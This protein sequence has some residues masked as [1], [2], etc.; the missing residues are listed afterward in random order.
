[1]KKPNL[2]GRAVAFALCFAGIVSAATGCGDEGTGEDGNESINSDIGVAGDALRSCPQPRM[3]Q[4]HK[5]TQAAIQLL[6]RV[7]NE[8]PDNQGYRLALA[9]ATSAVGNIVRG[10][11]EVEERRAC[12]A[13][14]L[15]A[16]CGPADTDKPVVQARKH[17]Q[18]AL[19]NIRASV[20]T[21]RGAKGDAITDLREAIAFIKA[22]KSGNTVVV[23]G[24]D[25]L[26]PNAD[27]VNTCAPP[28]E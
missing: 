25:P 18:A 10:V 22:A 7:V 20:G 9:E 3:Q 8:E 27:D 5:R 26:D 21:K 6:Q 24:A 19:K 23:N 4:A 11:E 13:P 14:A 16:E 17:L 1:M 12:N 2:A 15:I 28:T